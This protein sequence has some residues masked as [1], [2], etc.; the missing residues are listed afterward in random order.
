M[1]GLPLGDIRMVDIQP[2]RACTTTITTVSLLNTV[3][4]IALLDAEYSS[5]WVDMVIKELSVR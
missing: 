2:A 1:L 4:S 5:A 3:F